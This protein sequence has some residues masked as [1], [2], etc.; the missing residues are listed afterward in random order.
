MLSASLCSQGVISPSAPPQPVFVNVTNI[1]TV[2]SAGISVSVLASDPSNP[3]IKARSTKHVLS[4]G[5]PMCYFCC[6]VCGSTFHCRFI[7]QLG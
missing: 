3:L 2:A 1:G 7:C 6:Q 4:V 5:K